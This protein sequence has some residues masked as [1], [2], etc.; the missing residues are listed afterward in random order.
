M[1]G[2][3]EKQFFDTYLEPENA[4]EHFFWPLI[5]RFNAHSCFLKEESQ[6]FLTDPAFGSWLGEL[7]DFVR[8]Q[9][10]VVADFFWDFAEESRKLALLDDRCLV[11][12]AQVSGVT[13]HARELA[14]VVERTARGVLCSA[15]GE[16]LF[17]YALARGQYQAGASEEI[18]AKRDT[19]LSLEA[20]CQTHGWLALRFCAM[21]WP[22]ALRSRFIRRL[23]SFSDSPTDCTAH[24]DDARWQAL[25]RMLKKCLLREVAP[26][27]AAYF[28]A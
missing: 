13:L 6:A 19:H 12:L 28:S 9:S 17:F 11:H 10:D 8:P 23:D 7:P 20:R 21:A 24:L 22:E 25:W 14:K 5:V 18:F 15:L 26:S 4:K 2:L 27:W 3:K 1:S 16:K